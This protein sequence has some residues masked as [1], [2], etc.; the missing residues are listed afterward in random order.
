M[1]K[2]IPAKISSLKVGTPNKIK[3]NNI[4]IQNTKGPFN[5]CHTLIGEGVRPK[6]WH[7][8]RGIN[9]KCGIIP[10]KNDTIKF[11]FIL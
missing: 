5:V 4:I 9:S 2:S 10:L 7:K 11:Q 8:G 1:Q 6:K 3:S